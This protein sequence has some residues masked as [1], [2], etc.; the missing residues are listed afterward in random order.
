VTSRRRGG[1]EVTRAQY[2]DDDEDDRGF[3]SR[4]ADKEERLRAFA[5]PER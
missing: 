4:S 5:R 1:E 2:E 3:V